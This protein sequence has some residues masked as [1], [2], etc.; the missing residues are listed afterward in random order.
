VQATVGTANRGGGGGAAGG[1][2][3]ENIAPNYPGADGAD[4]VV[5]I[6]FTEGEIFTIDDPLIHYEFTSV[7]GDTVVN[8][9]SLGTAADG[10]PQNA[11]IDT[12]NGIIGNAILFTGSSSGVITKNQVLLNDVNDITMAT[13]VYWP[14]TV[15]SYRYVIDSGYTTAGGAQIVTF[16]G[17][18]P[19]VWCSTVRQDEDPVLTHPVDTSGDWHH[20][21]M[22]WDG[23]TDENKFYYDGGLVLTTAHAGY[24]IGIDAKIGFGCQS[25]GYGQ[26]WAGLMD[27]AY[28]FDRALS[29]TEI[30]MLYSIGA[31]SQPSMG[32][33]GGASQDQDI[34]YGDASPTPTKGTD[35]GTVIRADTSGANTFTIDNESPT[36]EAELNSLVVSLTGADAADFSVTQPVSSAI[37][38]DETTTFTVSFDPLIGSANGT[39]SAI[40]NIANNGASDP[41]TFDVTGVATNYPAPIMIASA[42]VAPG[43]GNT[44]GT[45]RALNDAQGVTYS[46]DGG[47]DEADFSIAVDQLIL[48]DTAVLGDD[49]R[50]VNVKATSVWGTS[51]IMAIEVTVA[52]GGGGASATIFVFR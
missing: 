2:T 38:V 12:I 24:D 43:A 40:V 36:A 51:D 30:G 47:A 41:W 5:I 50:Y 22:T 8:N 11:S 31:G 17:V 25:G 10:D 33:K 37:A 18:S 39:K 19:D 16:P 46:K 49:P 7:A 29:A 45:L 15:G 4:G 35:F 34:V 42:E 20:L 52:A 1:W 23:D 48:D 6:E 44:V 27:D 21:A 28:V 9:G 3:T 13:W 14:A 26:S 32:V